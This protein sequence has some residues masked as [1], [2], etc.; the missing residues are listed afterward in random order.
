MSKVAQ[1]SKSGVDAMEANQIKK[2]KKPFRLYEHPW[3]G[4]LASMCTSIAAMM[5][6]GTVVFGL[7]GLPD[8]QPLA[9]FTHGISHHLLTALVLTPFL[10][11][12]PKGK[13]SYKKYLEDIGLTRIQPFLRLVL[14]A[15]SCYLILALCQVLASIVYR[16]FED[17]PV[18]WRFI[19][20]AFDLSGDLPPVSA[21]LLVTIPS[22]FEE[23][24]AR[25]IILTTFLNKYSGRKAIIFS[26]IG[27][28]LMHLLNL[29]NGRELI[30]VLG[31]VLWTFLIA[32]FY[33]YVFVRTGSLLPSMI[34]HYLSN[35]FI[36]SLTGYIQVRASLEIQAL[37]GVI[38]S[39]GILPTTL[40]IL[41][42]RFFMMKWIPVS[43]QSYLRR[44]NEKGL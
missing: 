17:Y 21:G 35:A 20:E 34:V 26:S 10:L 38:L 32:L 11:R 39:H 30:W 43:G 37:Y 13:S 36:G 22:M 25:G 41:W 23:L 5:L 42:A 18:T 27:F 4:M 29:A 31:Q 3:L 8:D 44:A 2:T 28:G 33:G 7:L 1:F 40:M 9:Q 6:A 14:L 15:L 16:L 24:S 19:R 12:L